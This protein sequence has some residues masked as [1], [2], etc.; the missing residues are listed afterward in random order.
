[1]RCTLR[2]IVNLRQVFPGGLVTIA[3]LRHILAS[4]Q[5]GRRP[6]GVLHAQCASLM[7]SDVW[8]RP[9]TPI[10]VHMLTLMHGVG[11]QRWLRHA[12]QQLTHPVT[13]PH[14]RA[15]SHLRVQVASAVEQVLPDVKQQLTQL[16]N[17]L[18]EVSEEVYSRGEVRC[19]ACTACT[20]GTALPC[21]SGGWGHL[22]GQYSVGVRRVDK[23]MNQ[24]F[25]PGHITP[26]QPAVMCGTQSR[27]VWNS[28]L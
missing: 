25:F 3:Q 11:H 5:V 8:Q 12:K 2:S 10:L 15:C 21:N 22:K 9:H 20:G 17:Q 28:P 19:T 6:P 1:M 18:E 14:L 27:N 26:R 7:L 16:R 23:T 4:G 13:H 24:S